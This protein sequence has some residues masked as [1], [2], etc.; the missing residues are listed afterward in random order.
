MLLVTTRRPRPINYHR[1]RLVTTDTGE[2]KPSSLTMREEKPYW[3]QVERKAQWVCREVSEFAKG[4]QFWLGN[5]RSNEGPGPGQ[6]STRAPCYDKPGLPWSPESRKGSTQFWMLGLCWSSRASDPR[7]WFW[8]ERISN[9]GAEGFV[10]KAWWFGRGNNFTVVTKRQVPVTSFHMDNIVGMTKAV[11]FLSL[12][13]DQED[14]R[15]PCGQETCTMYDL[16]HVH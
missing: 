3:C 5:S 14:L 2:L 7:D 16:R 1:R 12:D 10:R 15:P 13:R 4:T 11:R 9:R 6:G 8:N